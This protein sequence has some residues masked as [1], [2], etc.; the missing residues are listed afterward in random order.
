MVMD[1]AETVPVNR[2]PV[3][4]ITEAWDNPGWTAS[5]YRRV[6]TPGAVPSRAPAGGDEEMRKAWAE[7]TPGMAPTNRMAKAPARDRCSTARVRQGSDRSFLRRLAVPVSSPP[8]FSGRPHALPRCA[9]TRGTR[10]VGLTYI[11]P[12][13]SGD[14]EYLIQATRPSLPPST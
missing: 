4:S 14:P 11:T 1:V 7:A 10:C 3:G 2:W 13:C 9:A 5:E 8:R 12:P 6:T